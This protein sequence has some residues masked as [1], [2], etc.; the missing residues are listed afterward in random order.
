M[1]TSVL[2]SLSW[3][4]E[5]GSM[6]LAG[7]RYLMVRPATVVELLKAA[8]EM[9]GVDGARALFIA[10]GTAG[11]SQAATA[12]A[13]ADPDPRVVSATM[14]QKGTGIGWG[15]IRVEHAEVAGSELRFSAE[16]SPFAEGYGESD[17][18]V[19][20]FL[21]GALTGLGRTVLGADAVGEETAC[22]AMGAP[23]CEFRIARADT[24]AS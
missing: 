11:G 23:R 4:P 10:A 1:K 17:H 21:T 22:A 16:F 20:H 24:S 3:N 12:Y 5:Q 13:K 9:H 14:A 18:P 2:P 7:S 8:E 19:C 15:K 6:S